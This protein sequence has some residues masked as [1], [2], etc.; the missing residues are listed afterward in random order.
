MMMT[1]MPNPRALPTFCSPAST[2][3]FRN[4]PICMGVRAMLPLVSAWAVA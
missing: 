3:P 1:I 4:V 2:L